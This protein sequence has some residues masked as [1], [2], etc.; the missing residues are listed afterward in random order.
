MFHYVQD[1][2]ALKTSKKESS[3][4]KR[5]RKKPQRE[6]KAGVLQWRLEI[7]GDVWSVSGLLCGEC[8]QWEGVVHHY[9]ECE[10]CGEKLRGKPDDGGAYD[11]PIPLFRCT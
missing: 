4:D 11:S 1:F 3:K 8:N 9:S 6:I 10:A 2:L 5:E 7:D